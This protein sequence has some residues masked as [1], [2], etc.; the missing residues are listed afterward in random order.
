MFLY[1]KICTLVFET[2]K[3][4]EHCCSGW[5]S[6]WK[7]LCLVQLFIYEDALSSAARLNTD[8]Y[9]ANE[10]NF[11]RVT[12]IILAVAQFF[13]FPFLA[14][15]HTH[16][17]GKLSTQTVIARGQR[18]NNPVLHLAVHYAGREDV[19]WLPCLLISCQWCHFLAVDAEEPTLPKTVKMSGKDTSKHPLPE[20]TRASVPSHLRCVWS[21]SQD[22]TCGGVG[23]N[24]SSCWMLSLALSNHAI[25]IWC[26]L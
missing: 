21:L 16:F 19:A 5:L 26:S 9:L 3:D 14:P 22:G 18:S 1:C 13:A 6:D 15:H 8:T 17:N 12:Q 10:K 4:G 7:P 20:E 2:Q 24:F 25:N 23:E 11:Y